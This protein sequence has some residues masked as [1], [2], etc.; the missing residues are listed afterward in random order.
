MDTPPQPHGGRTVPALDPAPMDVYALRRREAL[1]R[2]AAEMFVREGRHH[3]ID[4]WCGDGYGT[5]IF[6]AAGL[7]V[8]GFAPDDA[9]ARRA[10]RAYR[11]GRIAFRAGDLP[12]TSEPQHTADAVVCA[13][14]LERLDDPRPLLAE[15]KRLLRP[16]GVAVVATPNRLTSS[17]GRTRPL[18]GEHAWEY[19]PDEFQ[20]LMAH[21][22]SDV[23]PSGVFHGRRLHR[24]ERVLGT[25]LAGTMHR[26]PPADRAGW[27]RLALHNL[28]HRAF[29][30]RP[31]STRTALDLVAVARV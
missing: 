6:A 24:L 26:I 17:P 27:L 22:F 15:M 4:L 31:G 13:G 1:Y 8:V 14:L 5:A 21:G 9:A 30:I 18:R 16:A 20:H 10:A 7:D 28:S 3:I 25:S 2:W 12:R 11:F 29:E 19:T 23:R